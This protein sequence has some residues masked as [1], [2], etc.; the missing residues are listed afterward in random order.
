MNWK[1]RLTSLFAILSMAAISIISI[2][3]AQPTYS[4]SAAIEPSAALIGS[5]IM[6]PTITTILDTTANKVS[7]I[8]NE[9]AKEKLFESDSRYDKRGGVLSSDG[10]T[11]YDVEN[12]NA[13][14]YVIARDV[15]GWDYT[16]WSFVDRM[17]AFADQTGSSTD[18]F[19]SVNVEAPV[20]LVLFHLESGEWIPVGGWYCTTGRKYVSSGLPRES[21]GKHIIENKWEP[22]TGPEPAGPG[23]CLDF[24]ASYP[25][26]ILPSEGGRNDS[27]SFHCGVGIGEWGYNNLACISVTYDR[28][29]WLY[30]NIP[31]NTGIYIDGRC[32]GI[33][34]TDGL[35]DTEMHTATIDD[36]FIR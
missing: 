31:T 36:P 12:E 1:I 26:G 33:G 22:D 29:K 25:D 10:K 4:Y 35:S 5:Y 27:A 24:I 28:S 2:A 13:T 15:A 30:D 9:L 6:Q 11:I 19:I 17:R 32:G 21:G 8:Q 16:D 3:V 23:Y 7:E 20:R 18:W 34:S 14:D